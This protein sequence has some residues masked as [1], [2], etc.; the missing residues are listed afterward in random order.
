MSHE[1]GSV[2]VSDVIVVGGGVI[3]LSI[4]WRSAA[5]GATVTV[6]DDHRDGAASRSAGGMIAPVTEVHYGEEALL[7]LNLAS[8]RRYPSF[9]EELEAVSGEDVG[10]RTNGTLAV[11]RDSDDDAALDDLYR[12]QKTL[13]LDVQRLTGREC[14]ELEPMLTPGIRSG[15]L[16]DGDHQIDARRL[17]DALETACRRSNVKIHR[18]RVTGAVTA[19]DGVRGVRL[20]DG[21]TITGGA[22][23]LAGGCWSG[24]L[25]GVPHEARPPVRPVKGQLLYLAAPPHP[26]FAEHTIRGMVK[27]SNVYM[28]AL[29]DGRFAVGATT[30]EMGFDTALTAG[31]VYQLLRD[32][33]EILPGITE[34]EIAET[35]VGLRPGSPDNAPLL[36]RSGLEGLVIA[37][38]HYRNG[39]LLT[40]VTGDAI[41][42]LLATGETP[43][44]IARFSPRRFS[45]EGAT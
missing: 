33:Y 45:S 20:D 1:T 18:R 4:A 34:L 3:G 11:A 8:A 25:D 36:G 10:Y 6:V 12:F 42:E 31:G 23:V 37:S 38:G 35:T 19:G 22:V 16:V 15:A 26:P 5:L 13:D 7:E 44:L 17:V 40:P 24:Q 27:G 32:V 14:R 29:G 2:D 21:D 30:E 39:I 41:A 28:V 9:V 43:E